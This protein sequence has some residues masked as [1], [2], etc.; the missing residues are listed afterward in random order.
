MGRRICRL[1]GLEGES[2]DC[3]IVKWTFVRM[4]ME[5]QGEDLGIGMLAW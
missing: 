2:I 3:P 5:G 1:V 4:E